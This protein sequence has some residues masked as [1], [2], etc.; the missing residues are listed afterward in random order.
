[1]TQTFEFTQYADITE[2]VGN[3]L[4][5]HFAS[6]LSWGAT[7][8]QAVAIAARDTFGLSDQAWNGKKGSNAYAA[9]AGWLLLKGYLTN[10]ETGV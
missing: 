10:L 7:T 6:A 3:Q 4:I 1:M 8:G 5:K 9:A 2:E